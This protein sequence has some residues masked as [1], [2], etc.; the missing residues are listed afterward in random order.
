M[1]P[2]FLIGAVSSFLVI[3]QYFVNIQVF[4]KITRISMLVILVYGGFLFRQSYKDYNEMLSRRNI[5]KNDII[6]LSD[7]T[8]VMKYDNKLSYIPSAVCRFS[9]EGGYV[10]GCVMELLQRVMQIN[11]I[12][13]KKG[14]TTEVALFAIALAA[15]F[16]ILVL[17]YVGARWW[18]GWICPLSTLGDIFDTLRRWAKLPHFKLNRAFKHS[19]FYSGISLASFSLLLAKAYAHVNE[20]GMFMGC[21]IPLYPF[22]KICPAQQVCPVAAKGPSGYPPLAGTEWLFG[23]FKVCAIFLVII[24]IIS[25]ITARKLWC[26]FCPMGIIGGVFNKNSFI[27]IK[28]DA[29]KCNG[30]GVCND[31]CP[32]DIHKVQKEMIQKDVTSF[33]CVY[34]L[35]CVDNCPQDKCLSL[36]FANK[37]IIESKFM[38]KFK[39]E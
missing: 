30:C 34:C 24:F 39:N 9:A 21:K 27:S 14:D 11:L 16:T 19:Y 29:Q 22:C 26:Y 2:A 37:K 17:L 3:V 38:E 20:N 5:V 35:N 28:K 1:R 23:F 13:V 12:K 8:P 6:A 25:F 33:N 32:M 15:I 31:V 18:C 4:R 10:Q 7:T 36:Q